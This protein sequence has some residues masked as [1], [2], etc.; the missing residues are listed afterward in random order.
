MY[1]E[2][3]TM[4]VLYALVGVVQKLKIISDS[5]LKVWNCWLLMYFFQVWHAH[6]IRTQWISSGVI[7]GHNAT[8]LKFL[9]LLLFFVYL[10]ELLRF[11]FNL[12][13]SYN[14]FEFLGGVTWHENCSVLW[15][16]IWHVTRLMYI[17]QFVT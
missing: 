11:G 12:L 13:K 7:F 3:E 14:I 17:L 6:W 4:S 2:K 8:V 10:M 5:Q 15:F 9:K 16:Q 1:S